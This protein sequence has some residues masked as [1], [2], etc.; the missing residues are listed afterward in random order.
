MDDAQQIDIKEVMEQIQEKIRK[1]QQELSHSAPASALSDGPIAADLA[2]LRSSYDIYHIH[3]TSHRKV[4]GRLV[5]L[6][7]QALCKLLTPIL[8]RQ[9]A[10]NTANTRIASHLCKQVVGVLQQQATTSQALQEI[11]VEQVE[12]LYQVVRDMVGEQI[13]G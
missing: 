2:S 11:V 4:L 8:E 12:G 10:Y 13:G 3:F 6:A 5:V 9:S 7:K 1:R